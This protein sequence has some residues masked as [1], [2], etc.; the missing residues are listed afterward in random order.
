MQCKFYADSSYWGEGIPCGP[1]EEGLT[2][3]DIDDDEKIEAYIDSAREDY[4]KAF[5]SYIKQHEEVERY[6]S[7]QDYLV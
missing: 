2:G 4:R 1:D 6:F 5:R 7:Y 3:E